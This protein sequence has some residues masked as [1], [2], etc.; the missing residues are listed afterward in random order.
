MDTKQITTY[1]IGVEATMAVISGKWKPVILCH[2]NRQSLRNGELVR[3]IP[4]IS[5]KMLTQQLRELEGDDIICRK[6]YPQIPPK[7]EYCL[8]DYGRTLAEVTNAMCHWGE[9]YIAKQRD[10]GNEIDLLDTQSKYFQK[11]S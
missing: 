6:V 9:K 1:N 11:T 7:V 3:V 10:A 2:L 5:Q 4:N 8:T